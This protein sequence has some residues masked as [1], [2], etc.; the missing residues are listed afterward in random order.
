MLLCASASSTHALD[1]AVPAIHGDL[2]RSL[3]GDGTGVV[4][5]IVDSGVDDLHPALAGLDSWGNPRMV[6]EDNFVSTEEENTGD[7]VVG[8]G[9]SVASAALSR[10]AN[11]TGMA[12]DARFINARVLNSGNGFPNDVP[13]K[14]GIG[15][16]IEQGANVINLSLNFFSANSSGNSQMD[17]M[18]DWAAF[19]RGVHFAATVGNIGGG[20]GTQNVRGPGSAYNAVTVGRTTFDFNQVHSDSATAFTQDGR[21]KPD[22]VAPGT[23]LTLAND[24]WEGPAS[25]WDFGLNGTSFAAPLVAGLMAQQIEAGVAHELSTSPLVVKATIMNSASKVLDK[26]GNPW[27]P[28]LEHSDSGVMTAIHSLDTDSGAGQI[29]GLRLATQYLAGEKSPGAVDSI[30]WDYGTV[31]IGEFV[32]YMIEPRLM[33]G[34]TLTAT[35]TWFRHVGR[36]DNGDGV[37]NASDFFFELA[38][39]SNLDLQVY[40]NGDLF[41]ESAS[42]LDNVEHLHFNV[43]RNASYTLRVVGLD[44]T[45]ASEAF[46]LA[47][48][49]TPVPEPGIFVLGFIAAAGFG[50]R[51]LCPKRITGTD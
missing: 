42:L 16:A 23:G 40:R 1:D 2:S 46:A 20:S 29:D 21:M 31:S 8:H 14:N 28:A 37:V 24:D 33:A 3:L 9:T 6:A 47:W 4:I 10:H 49:G 51:R 25:D 35:L 15:F 7:D 32:D 39:L 13:V 5:G 19:E 30:G 44:A 17:L 50:V 48:Y 22:V 27:Q 38:D 11:F 12:P 45:S 34:S 36:T 26:Q 41:A 43:D 18:I